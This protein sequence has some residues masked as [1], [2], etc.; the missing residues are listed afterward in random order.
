MEQ[1]RKKKSTRCAALIAAAGSG[2]R[3]GGEV[4]KQFIEVAGKTVLRH[5]LELFLGL[6]AVEKIVV[7]LPPDSVKPF[8]D[9][10]T[11]AER[12]RVVAVAGGRSRQ[13]SVYNGLCALD[14]REI[15]VVAI[16]D[17]ARPLVDREVVQKTIELAAEGKAAMACAP[18]RDTVKRAEAGLVA[19]TVDRGDLWLAQTPQTFPLEMILEAHRRARAEGLAATDDAALCERLGI[20]VHLVE[21]TAANLKIT[22]P[23]DLDYVR[24]RL[25]ER[26]VATLRIGEGYDIHRLVAGRRL[27][28]GG[29]EV[30]FE[31]GL[32]GHS[33]ADVL[34]HAVTDALLGACALGDIGR[35]FPDDDPAFREADS[36]G[37][38]AEVVGRVRELGYGIVNLDSTVIAQR[39]RLAPYIY[40]IRA[41]IAEILGVEVSAVSVKAKTNEKLGPVGRGEGIAAQ[42]VA[43]LSKAY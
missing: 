13:E 38:L 3:M 6:P 30:P 42:A 23:Y 15:D 19:A 10:L 37:L 43:L 27:V 40:A 11:E 5:T 25:G 35:H 34:L 9:S 39:P 24:Y 14:P 7:A 21:S 32:E 20:P 2:R 1:K 28:L 16:H 29:V 18:M 31:L 12:K 8:E 41:R 4:P 17:A 36:S 33:D 22:G 26:A